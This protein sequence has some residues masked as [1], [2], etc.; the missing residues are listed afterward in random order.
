M[1]DPFIPAQEILPM[2][3]QNSSLPLGAPSTTVSRRF[4]K[5]GAVA[6]TALALGTP[7][8]H[9]TG[10]VLD[11]NDVTIAPTG[12]LNLKQGNLIVRG[13]GGGDRP[14][15]GPRGEVRDQARAR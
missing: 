1:N 2:N 10:I 7:L 6:F 15:A 13:P 4:V 5:I 11:T 9:A 12:I 14:T 3:I 8:L